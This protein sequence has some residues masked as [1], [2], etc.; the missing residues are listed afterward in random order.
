MALAKRD[1]RD[2]DDERIVRD[3]S[4]VRVPM[5]LMDNKP[6]HRPGPVVVADADAERRR[7]A[8]LYDAYDQRISEAWKDQAP[9]TADRANPPPTPA[10][11]SDCYKRYD[12][13]IE[14][15]WRAPPEGGAA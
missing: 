4:G 6:Q 1:Q 2:E 10:E 13:R 14:N 3:R 12:Q 11:V 9:P 7:R 8:A 5:M 15:A